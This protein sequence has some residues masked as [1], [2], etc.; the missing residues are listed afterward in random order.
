MQRDSCTKLGEVC[1]QDS[2]P[3]THHGYTKGGMITS[4]SP[5]AIDDGY[6]R[7]SHVLRG[8]Y[9]FGIWVIDGL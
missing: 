8:V 2:C 7:R 5:V 3:V 4:A 1:L 9:Y 6:G